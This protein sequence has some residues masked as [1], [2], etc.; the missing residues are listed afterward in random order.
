MN[1][2]DDKYG[3]RARRA[4]E[5]RPLVQEKIKAEN[6]SYAEAGR[7][8]GLSGMAVRRFLDEGAVPF[9]PSLDLYQR[10][11]EGIPA[12]SDTPHVSAN[13]IRH[14]DDIHA[15]PG[16]P[17]LKAW[18]L[19]ELA[20]VYRWA[21]VHEAETASKARAEAAGKAEDASLARANAARGGKGMRDL[22]PEPKSR[23]QQRK[24]KN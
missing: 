2:E 24:R 21:A 5:L 14:I 1:N 8:I 17:E 13:V 16:S 12:T 22:E 11:V 7:D 23:T 18:W 4:N 6:K 9:E 15:S 10:W 3:I 20:S 19:S